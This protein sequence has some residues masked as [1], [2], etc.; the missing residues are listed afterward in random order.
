MPGNSSPKSLTTD[1]TDIHATLDQPHLERVPNMRQSQFIKIATAAAAIL[2]AATGCGASDAGHGTSA[3]PVVQNVSFPAGTTMNSI[4]KDGK[5][6]VGGK[7]DLPGLSQKNLTGKMEGF[8]VSIVNY[9]AG[10]LGL[11]PEQVE[12]TETS[13]ANR[14]QF[15]QQDKVDMVVSSFT[16]NDKRKKVIDFAGPYAKISSDLL[17][18]KGNPKGIKDPATPAGVVVCG[19]SGGSVVASIRENFPTVNLVEFDVA[20][21]CIEAIKNGQVD[22]YATDGPIGAGYVSVDK[23]KLQMLGIELGQP[24]YWGIGLSKGDTEFCKFLDDSLKKFGS[25]GS[26]KNAW[27]TY[28][29]AAKEQ[30][31]PTLDACS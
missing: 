5:L 10:Q 24:G 28:L 25:D 20:S 23:E 19:T 27:N 15:I 7:F 3:A 29:G 31:L 18:A 14:E 4:V 17:I 1:L 11:K 16:I 2:L 12:W 30:Q 21:K 6:R 26:Y 8:E 13:S 9:I 22:A